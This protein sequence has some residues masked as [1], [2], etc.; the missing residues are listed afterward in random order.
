MFGEGDLFFN[1]SH[2][3][4]QHIY[5]KT[6]Q[7]PWTTENK[8]KIAEIRQMFLCR[9][10]SPTIFLYS[11]YTH[12]HSKCQKAQKK[13]NVEVY[14]HAMNNNRHAYTFTTQHYKQ[15]IWMG[16]IHQHM[17]THIV[18]PDKKKW[19]IWF[20]ILTPLHPN[21]IFILTVNKL[22][23]IIWIKSTAFIYFIVVLLI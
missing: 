1:F 22:S 2:F 8:I 16:D 7:L 13:D 10:H 3:Y 18:I 11:A 9:L 21:W 15:W 4:F 20:V 19:R 14:V 17:Q 12:T 23:F 6:T 5:R